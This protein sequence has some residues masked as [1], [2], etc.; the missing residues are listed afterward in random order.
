MAGWLVQWMILHN[1]I[2]LISLFVSS[3]LHSAA[4]WQHIRGRIP[5]SGVWLVS[6]SLVFYISGLHLNGTVK[7]V[8]NRLQHSFTS[9]S[10][11]VKPDSCQ[12]D[13]LSLRHHGTLD[14]ALCSICLSD[15]MCSVITHPHHVHTHCTESSHTY[16][17]TLY[18]TA[19]NCITHTHTKYK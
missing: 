18:V 2:T 6:A 7:Q 12:S 4:P 10:A 8:P 15:D 11:E 17:S 9:C 13:V 5:L 19:S 3:L 1:W 14:V 16:L